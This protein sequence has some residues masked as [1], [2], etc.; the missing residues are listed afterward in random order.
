M[1]RRLLPFA[2]WEGISTRWL[3]V[4]CGSGLSCCLLI[5]G[6]LY[7]LLLQ[8]GLLP[9]DGSL[10]VPPVWQSFFATLGKTL[11]ALFLTALGNFLLLGLAACSRWLRRIIY[12]MTASLIDIPALCMIGLVYAV[13]PSFWTVSVI[14]AF[15]LI[16][17]SVH[18]V[19][20]AE[21][22]I[23]A[24]YIKSARAL[25]LD[26]WHFFWRLHIPFAFSD[27]VQCVL[28]DFPDFWLRILGAEAL[29]TLFSTAP[30]KGLGAEFITELYA[31]RSVKAVSIFMLSLLLI[32][33]VQ[34]GVIGPFL[35]RSQRYTVCTGT[36]EREEQD[37]RP[38]AWWRDP[39]LLTGLGVVGLLSSLLSY[40]LWPWQGGVLGLFS[41]GV[42]PLVVGG[43]FWGL[44]GGLTLSL[45]TVYRSILR[46]FSLAC[47]FF[48]FFLLYPF[49]VKQLG[50]PAVILPVL[51][52]LG[53]AGWGV[54]YQE[55]NPIAE[56]LLLMGQQLRLPFIPMWQHVKLP[57]LLP[58]LLQGALAVL[59]LFWSNVYL[60]ELFASESVDASSSAGGTLL[61]ALRSHA[62]G[63]QCLFLL[64]ITLLAAA[65]RWGVF[66]PLQERVSRKYKVHS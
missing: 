38:V 61:L 37:E 57:L 54:L 12:W 56:R 31:G 21:D 10:T 19:L 29:E 25:R 30:Y 44:I 7:F 47:A 16:V 59:F 48:P 43:L 33:V 40:E 52:V 3:F 11:L 41:Y 35:K 65:L 9:I 58:A 22:N 23:P 60:V 55:S 26:R 39:A 50:L 36:F 62:Y 15:S 66:I 27:L 6:G 28:R 34:H 2:N 5:M 17:R 42:L 53:G 14:A 63:V 49:C 32:A 46:R 64:F 8:G 20:R 45:P 51:A 1:R 13:L 24:D 4:C 18:V